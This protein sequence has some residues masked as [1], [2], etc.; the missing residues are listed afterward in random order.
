MECLNHFA[1]AIQAIAAIFILLL[2]CVLA[3]STWQYVKVSEALQKPCITV[4]SEPRVGEDMIIH[5]PYVTQ[6]AQQEGR[7]VIRNIGTGPALNVRFGFLHT[8]AEPGGP[9]MNPTGFVDYLQAG[10]QWRTQVARPTLATRNFAFD[11]TYES[12]SGKKY[13]TTINIEKGVITSL[14]FK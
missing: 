8:D 6:V 13:Q 9:V 11:A 3:Y 10:Q 14:S 7:V 2:T 1:P 5:A 12:L 4:Q